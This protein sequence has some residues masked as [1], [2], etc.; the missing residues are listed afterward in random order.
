MDFIGHEFVNADWKR[1]SPTK[2]VKRK[3]QGL[4]QYPRATEAITKAPAM[5]RRERSMVMRVSPCNV[6]YI[7]I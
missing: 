4:T 3:N 2:A 5:R 1:F 7:T 6:D